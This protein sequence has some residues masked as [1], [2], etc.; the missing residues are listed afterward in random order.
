M[1][2][3]TLLDEIGRQLGQANSKTPVY[4]PGGIYYKN[5][6]SNFAQTLLKGAI[7]RKLNV[8]SKLINRFC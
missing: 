4:F 5:K 6:I 8:K 2:L 7:N 1:L 3:G